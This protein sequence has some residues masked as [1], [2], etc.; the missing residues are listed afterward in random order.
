M[1]TYIKS[2]EECSTA[3]ACGCF[4][5][6]DGGSIEITEANK[7]DCFTYF[8]AYGDCQQS[9]GITITNS[10]E[11]SITINVDGGVDD[12]VA[13]DGVVYEEGEYCFFRAD[14]G[15]FTVCGGVNGAHSFSYQQV[16]S[17]GSSLNIKGIDNGYGGRISCKITISAA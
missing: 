6:A 12:D 1:A 4:P 2:C 9:I 13:F 3:D 8:A 15:W 14:C 5:I 7:T 10:T 17:I 16:L 11:S